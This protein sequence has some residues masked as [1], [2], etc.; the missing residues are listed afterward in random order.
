MQ[1]LIRATSIPTAAREL[2]SRNG[3]LGWLSSQLPLDIAERR[4][5]LQ[6]VC[7]MAQVVPWDKMAG[8]ADVVEAMVN[9]VGPD[10]AFALS[11]SAGDL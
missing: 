3:L 7:N 4:L 9:A 8:V 2:L 11:V 10:G 1:F 6:V 5:F